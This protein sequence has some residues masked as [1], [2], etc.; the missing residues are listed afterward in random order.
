DA[1]SPGPALGVRLA[2]LRVASGAARCTATGLEQRRQ[3]H[4]RGTGHPPLRT[5]C[6]HGAPHRLGQDG[7]RLSVRGGVAPAHSAQDRLMRSTAALASVW[8]LG[9]LGMATTG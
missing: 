7:P 4:R 1:G 9:I 5:P 2:T 8:W 6:G 3:L